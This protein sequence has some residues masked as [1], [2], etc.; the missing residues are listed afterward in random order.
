M[1]IKILKINP[2]PPGAIYI[3]DK[4]NAITDDASFSLL[5]VILTN[6][7]ETVYSNVFQHM[8]V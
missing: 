7:I 1:K 4:T 6:D 2:I 8:C 5:I 3:N